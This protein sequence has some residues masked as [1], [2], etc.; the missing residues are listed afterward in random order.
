M[1]NQTNWVRQT[2]GNNEYLKAARAAWNNPIYRTVLA[3]YNEDGE[4]A[5]E[6]YLQ[7]FQR[8]LKPGEVP[9]RLDGPLPGSIADKWAKEDAAEQYR[10]QSD[11]QILKALR[12]AAT[13]SRR[14][15]FSRLARLTEQ[16]KDEVLD[17]SD[18]HDR[19]DE[20]VEIAVTLLNQIQSCF[21]RRA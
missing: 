18:D 10:E 21:R 5:A 12:D 19:D 11:A 1:K 15:T 7:G 4:E 14:A 3:I 2:A 17:A 13:N 8:I 20:A 9:A 6:R 16:L